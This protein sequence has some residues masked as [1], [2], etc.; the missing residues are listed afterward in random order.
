[1]SGT[2]SRSPTEF[3]GV[4]EVTV[5]PDL[6]AFSNVDI[7]DCERPPDC[8]LIILGFKNVLTESAVRMIQEEALIFPHDDR[9]R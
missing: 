5:T 4:D 9:V 3:V 2:H 6:K 1:M 7:V 8:K